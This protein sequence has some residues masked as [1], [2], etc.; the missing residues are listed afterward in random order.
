MTSHFRKNVNTL[1]DTIAANQDQPIENVHRIMVEIRL[2]FEKLK[3]GTG[4][5]NDFDKVAAAVNVGMIRAEQI[6]PAAEETMLR[7]VQALA[8]CDAIKAKHKRYG[9]TGPDLIS[10]ADALDLYE[11][12]LQLSTPRKMMDAVAEMAKRIRK[13][14]V[15][16]AA[17]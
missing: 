11:Q 9:F 8:S 6:D 17:A 7:G 16:K 2:A 15:M 1:A 10:M 3:V 4:T 13:G 5:D 12:I 14:H